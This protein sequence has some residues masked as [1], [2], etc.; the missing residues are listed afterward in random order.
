M[1]TLAIMKARIADEIGDRS[2]LDSQIAYAINDAIAFYQNERFVFDESRD[3]TF[4]TV[5][6]QEFY[7]SA[8]NA[9]IPNMHKIDYVIL[10]L[11]SIPWVMHRRQPAD[12]EILNQNGLVSGQPWSWAWWNKQIRLGPIPDAVYSIRVAGDIKYAAPASDSEADNP[13]MTE[14]EKLIRTRAKYE[15]ALNVL[16]DTEMAQTCAAQVTEAYDNLKAR[17]N[18]ITGTG[19]FRPME[20]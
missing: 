7:G 11:G 14:A 4:S 20:F 9:A 17:T 19:I 1:S 10:Y 8:D 5:A 12:I 3:V 16:S 6:G 13:W 18:R 2:D 15:L